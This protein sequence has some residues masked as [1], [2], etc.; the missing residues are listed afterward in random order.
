MEPSWSIIARS[1][2]S[3]V[4]KLKQRGQKMVEKISLLETPLKI[5]FNIRKD[6]FE[7][8]AREE[9]ITLVTKMKLLDSHVRLQSS[10]TQPK[11][12]IEVVEIGRAHV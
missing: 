2:E 10:T 4:D 8:N 11:E 7:F 1:R 12:W 5:E 6:I 3:I 9:L